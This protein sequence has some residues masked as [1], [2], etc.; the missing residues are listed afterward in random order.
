MNLIEKFLIKWL[1]LVCFIFCLL[2][3]ASFVSGQNSPNKPDELPD[4]RELPK[5]TDDSIQG[6]TRKILLRGFCKKT[7]DCEQFIVKKVERFPQLSGV[8]VYSIAREYHFFEYVLRYKNKS[9]ITIKSDD[10][11]R[12]LKD[13]EMLSKP[14]LLSKFLQVYRYFKFDGGAINPVYI[15]D[16]AYLTENSEELKKYETGFEKI[17]YQSIHSPQI[18]KSDNDNVEIEFYVESR[19]I[20]EIKKTTARLSAKY[21]FQEKVVS[22]RLKKNETI[23]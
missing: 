5:I 20:G 14:D 17:S 15:V 13:Y 16:E 18:V 21:N 12:F 11:S 19:D 7:A 23:N 3:L 4:N 1:S 22:Y 8:E 2:A 9:Y 10:F 6:K